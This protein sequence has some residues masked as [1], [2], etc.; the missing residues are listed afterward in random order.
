MVMPLFLKVTLCFA[1][2]FSSCEKS[3]VLPSGGTGPL[4]ALWLLQLFSL[5][6]LAG[7]AAD[8]ALVGGLYALHLLAADGADHRDAHRRSGGPAAL[9]P[10]SLPR[11][12]D[13]GGA[14][15]AAGF[16]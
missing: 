11:A 1:A 9:P 7:G 4:K 16:D 12:A 3:P 10:H 8:G 5:E 15:G 6:V 14:G 2:I 13:V